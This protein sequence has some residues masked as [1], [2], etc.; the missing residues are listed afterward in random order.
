MEV[1]ADHR[2][3]IDGVKVRA[4][5]TGAARKTETI[6]GMKRKRTSSL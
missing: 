1:V 6:M 4:S 5:G 3:V 2:H